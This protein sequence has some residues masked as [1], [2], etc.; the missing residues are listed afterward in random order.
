MEIDTEVYEAHPLRMNIASPTAHQKKNA[1][2]KVRVGTGTLSGWSF[3]TSMR[4]P[5]RIAQ[6]LQIVL[7]DQK[8]RRKRKLGPRIW[9][10][11][12]QAWLFEEMK[13]EGFY[14]ERQRNP[15]N[16]DEAGRGRTAMS[17]VS[18]L[19]FLSARPGQ[20]LVVSPLG[21]RYAQALRDNDGILMEDY[22]L[23]AL[24]RFRMINRDGKPVQRRP[25]DSGEITA[26]LGHILDLFLDPSVEGV[27]ISEERAKYII[28]LAVSEK[29]KPQLLELVHCQGFRKKLETVIA[30]KVNTV[31]D[32]GD[33]LI[34][35]LLLTGMLKMDATDGN[36][37]IILAPGR[38]EQARRIRDA[39]L[40]PGRDQD[41]DWETYRAQLEA[42][43]DETFPWHGTRQDYENDCKSVARAIEELTG[44]YPD[45]DPADRR[46]HVLLRQRLGQAQ[47]LAYFNSESSINDF[48]RH[49]EVIRSVSRKGNKITSLDFEVAVLRSVAGLRGVGRFAPNYLK[50]M[51]GNPMSHAPG[52]DGDGW[53]HGTGDNGPHLLLEA[54]L[55]RGRDQCSKEWEPSLRHLRNKKVDGV[56]VDPEHTVGLL[57]VP[58]L[59]QDA[60]S[61]CVR[62][63]RDIQFESRPVYLLLMSNEQY[64]NLLENTIKD[65]NRLA[66]FD[67]LVDWIKRTCEKIGTTRDAKNPEV[68]ARVLD[69]E[70]QAWNALMASK[71]EEL[72]PRRT[73]RHGP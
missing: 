12:T 38:E 44:S 40:A 5:E 13:L 61:A 23:L 58:Q 51:K 34:R 67:E 35:Y 17:P 24:Y 26:P 18:Q 25:N 62:D 33:T 39:L 2:E 52:N 37:R 66:D 16:V 21:Q 22:M 36:T 1:Q 3:S 19:G 71:A 50:D 41:Q 69:G 57:V 59:H 15:D 64:A 11:A 53:V 14:N 68:Y 4:N 73:R 48:P 32:Y 30:G 10:H 45:Y 65:G 72:L 28:P 43:P 8:S 31:R 55:I 9:D 7:N 20:P 63:A 60:I 29:N 54:S 46:A 56:A 6:I 49:L 42:E 27:G 47:E 70:I